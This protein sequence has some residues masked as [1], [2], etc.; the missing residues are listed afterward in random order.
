MTSELIDTF[1]HPLQTRLLAIRPWS[2]RQSRLIP[3]Y[4]DRPRTFI[5][6]MLVSCGPSM[7]QLVSNASGGEVSILRMRY[8]S[9]LAL[10]THVPCLAG[11]PTAPCFTRK[12]WKHFSNPIVCE[13]SCMLPLK[14]FSSYKVN[15]HCPISGRTAA[16]KVLPA[17]HNIHYRA[18]WYAIMSRLAAKGVVWRQYSV[19]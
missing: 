7:T 11:L 12:V 18:L 14:W 4:Q 15:K 19:M 3:C 6:I 13:Y 5:H 9:T 2:A 17:W 10:D 1:R 8:I 16:F